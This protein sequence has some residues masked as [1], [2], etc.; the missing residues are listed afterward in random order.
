MPTHSAMRNELPG[1]VGFLT[2]RERGEIDSL[3]SSEPTGCEVPE[4]WFHAGQLRAWRSERRIVLLLAGTQSGKTV[5]GA[6]LL[7]REI[8]R[9]V[10]PGEAND[11]LIVGPNT[12][13]LKKKA[14]P[15][16]QSL[17]KGLAEYKATDKCFVFSPGGSRRLVGARCRIKVFVGYGHKPDSLEAAT[18][19]GI[20]ADECGQLDFVRES[21]EALQRR[22]A[23]NRARIFLT[24][25]P[26][27]ISGWLKE[28]ADDALSGRRDDV[29]VVRFKSIDN[30]AFPV[31]EYERMRREWPEWRFR[32]F[33]MAEFTKPAGAVYDCFSRPANVC[34]EFAI[35]AHWPRHVGVDFGE[36]NTAAV[37]LAED[38]ATL[39]LY[40]YGT[41]HAGG[42]TVEEHVGAMTR[43]AFSLPCSEQPVCF[44][45]SVG[46]SWSEDEWRK[47]YIAAGLPLTRPPIREVEVGIQRV[48]R[49]FKT[50]R[51][52][53]FSTCE[54][55][56][57]EIESYQ[58][59]VDDRGEPT[60][61]IKDKERFHR[62]DA[63]RYIV[64]LLRR[65]AE[66][67]ITLTSRINLPT[68]PGTYQ[69]DEEEPPKTRSLRRIV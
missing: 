63:L 26:Y 12:E 49:Q 47:D 11:Y 23:V 60:D 64:S 2:E 66:P 8:Q 62:L 3:V 17:V 41:Y 5:T 34:D 53:V 16:F 55:M 50:G 35:P 10:A 19:K 24:T 69:D 45:H 38:P 29:D 18:Y 37:F 48:Y 52:R 51:L 31:E 58:R 1:L 36:T 7:L 40:I 65:S 21:W 27:T 20:W 68:R 57:A 42:R 32:L 46:G 56:I 4:E 44:E 59:E 67:E 13:L 6:R 14:L 15:E 9:T 43:K 61:R 22:A 54:K 28:L 30:P 39:R 25:T 33:C